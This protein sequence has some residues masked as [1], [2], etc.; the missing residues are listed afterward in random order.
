MVFLFDGLLNEFI[1]STRSG[2]WE[3]VH[4]WEEID[5]ELCCG[6]CGKKYSSYFRT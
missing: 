5:G 2:G 3:R 4:D 1:R 6:F